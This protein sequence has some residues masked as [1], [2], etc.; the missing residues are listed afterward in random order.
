MKTDKV[1][2]ESESVTAVLGAS[3]SS[4][5]RNIEVATSEQTR[6]REERIAILPSAP[7]R[8]KISKKKSYTEMKKTLQHNLGNISIGTNVILAYD[9][10]EE[11]G[12]ELDDVKLFVTAL[13][14]VR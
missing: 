4:S 12:V 1:I 13:A 9:Q 11:M 14:G 5:Q 10:A 3:I 8:R 6:S 7:K 2:K